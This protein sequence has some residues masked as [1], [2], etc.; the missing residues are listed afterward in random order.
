MFKSRGF[1]L[2]ELVMIILILGIIAAV[3]LPTFYSLKDDADIAALRAIVGG[4]QAGISTYYANQCM[5]GTCAWPD[6]LNTYASCGCW[7]STAKPCFD[8]VLTPPIT[9]NTWYLTVT[10]TDILYQP[11]SSGKYWLYR[12]DNST[13]EFWCAYG[14]ECSCP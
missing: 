4:V 7:C 3:A 12:Y 1:T 5:L 11:G 13:G 9:D 2:I 14:Y 8:T 10:A 6:K